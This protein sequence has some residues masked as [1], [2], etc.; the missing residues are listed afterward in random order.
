VENNY[1]PYK[2]SLN[3][4]LYRNEQKIQTKKFSTK[5]TKKSRILTDDIIYYYL[6]L[7]NKY[8]PKYGFKK[9][10]NKNIYSD[11]KYYKDYIEDEDNRYDEYEY[12]YIYYDYSSDE[13]KY[14]ELG[15]ILCE[16]LDPAFNSKLEYVKVDYDNKGKEEIVYKY[17]NGARYEPQYDFIISAR[18]DGISVLDEVTSDINLNKIGKLKN[19]FFFKENGKIITYF[20]YEN[21]E[22]ERITFIGIKFNGNKWEQVDKV[23]VELK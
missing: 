6:G 9:L 21:F 18:W 13:I 1:T 7:E 8:D 20:I 5:I 11:E 17:M 10:T 2:P 16:V 12:E 14:T 22:N 4:S 15:K 3:Y 23:E 19:I